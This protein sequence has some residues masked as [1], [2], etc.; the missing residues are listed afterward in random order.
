MQDL[1][2]LNRNLG[3][4]LRDRE[5]LIKRSE[6]L[7]NAM[8][9]LYIEELDSPETADHGLKEWLPQKYWEFI[10]QKVKS[11][12]KGLTRA[13]DNI[14][15]FT[16]KDEFLSLKEQTIHFLDWGGKYG[17]SE[18]YKLLKNMGKEQCKI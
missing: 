8:Y 1:D 16:E 3:K 10:E 13:K 15:D 7:F 11:I 4:V 9:E 5:D 2:D 14:Y 18:Q 17:M 12:S 6:T